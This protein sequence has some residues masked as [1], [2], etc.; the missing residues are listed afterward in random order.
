[1]ANQKDDILTKTQIIEFES[2][3]WMCTKVIDD[4]TLRIYLPKA[5][6]A[7]PSLSAKAAFREGFARGTMFSTLI[8][9]KSIETA[10][11]LVT[12]SGK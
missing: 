9:A 8:L 5:F 3:D 6:N 10:I 1:M 12:K 2:R 4:T 11:D 7:D